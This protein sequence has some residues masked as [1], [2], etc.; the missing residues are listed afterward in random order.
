MKEQC[1]EKVYDNW[2]T[3]QCSRYA[4]KDGFCKQH[5]PDTVEARIK[6][7]TKKM[8]E[9]NYR[10]YKRRAFWFIEEYATSEDLG[11]LSEK[12]KQQEEKP[13]HKKPLM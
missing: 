9:E 12:I 7:A 8:D 10:R 13:C 6:K 11:D 1:R 5:H 3:R 4:V 2:E